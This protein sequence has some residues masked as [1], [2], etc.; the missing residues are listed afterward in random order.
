[1][2]ADGAGLVAAEARVD[3][4]LD[5]F[6]RRAQ[7]AR[8]LS[9]QMSGMTATATSANHLVTITVDASGMLAGVR[10]DDRVRRHSGRWIAD[11]IEATTQAALR[12][13]ADQ[14]AVAV[15]RTVGADSPEGQAIMAAWDSRLGPAPD[16][17]A[18]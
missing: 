17:D 8:Q 10:L 1:M 18:A 5:R 9:T 16:G 6:E 11:E 14:I 12:L 7:R 15:G 13:L 2:Y 4:W 3:G